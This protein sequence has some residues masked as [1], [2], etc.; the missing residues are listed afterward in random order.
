MSVRIPRTIFMRPD[1]VVNPAFSEKYARAS[2]RSFQ[3]QWKPAN[4]L[5][6]KEATDHYGA[7]KVL[8]W[9]GSEI[10]ARKGMSVPERPWLQYGSE[11]ESP[12]CLIFDSGGHPKYVVEDEAEEWWSGIEEQLKTE[13]RMEVESSQ[14]WTIAIDGLRNLLADDRLDAEVIAESGRMYPIPVEYWRSRAAAHTFGD[15]RAEVLV[16]DG[17]ST[18]LRIKGPVLIE[19]PALERLIRHDA[20]AEG[21]ATAASG[22]AN[23]ESPTEIQKPDRDVPLDTAKH[24]YLAYMLRAVREVAF[25][26]NHRT[27][28]KTIEA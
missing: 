21:S 17:Y 12:K 7:Y 20:T 4:K 19:K 11:R 23:L 1:W 15:Q 26:H 8:G 10:E 9:D 5:F 14:R 16:G 22:C 6:L 27:P 18:T 24:P 25:H 28:K 13:W 3:N 2:D